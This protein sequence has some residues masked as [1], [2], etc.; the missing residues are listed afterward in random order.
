MTPRGGLR[1]PMHFPGR[2]GRAFLKSAIELPEGEGMGESKTYKIVRFRF[3]GKNET[4]RTGLT[5][6]EAQAWCRREDT[7]GHGWF[8]GY[9]EEK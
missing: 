5:L 8:D 1:P 9:T 3:N 2:P 6:N 7:Q 4:V